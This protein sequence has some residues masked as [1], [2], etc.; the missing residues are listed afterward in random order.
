MKVVNLTGFTVF[1]KYAICVFRIE[2]SLPGTNTHI[3]GES[4]E[5]VMVLCTVA[6]TMCVLV[7]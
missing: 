4:R 7:Q 5:R 2:C 6:L 1:V 3:Q